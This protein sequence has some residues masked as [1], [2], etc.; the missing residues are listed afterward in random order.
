[1]AS[2]FGVNAFHVKKQWVCLCSWVCV[3]NQCAIKN[4][5]INIC[6]TAFPGKVVKTAH[7]AHILH[8]TLFQWIYLF[9]T[10]L[11]IPI[12]CSY[13]WCADVSWDPFFFFEWFIYFFTVNTTRPKLR[14]HWAQE[15]F[16]FQRIMKYL[17][18]FYSISVVSLCLF[19]TSVSSVDQRVNSHQ[20]RKSRSFCPSIASFIVGVNSHQEILLIVLIAHC[21]P[22]SVLLIPPGNFSF[23]LLHCQLCC[24]RR[25]LSLAQQISLLVLLNSN[26]RPS[27]LGPGLH[28]Y[29]PRLFLDRAPPPPFCYSFC[30]L[31]HIRLEPEV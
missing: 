14:F 15:N 19:C 4:R 27:I 6:S 25:K 18:L 11:F 31:V 20:W 29:P 22:L 2:K 10:F 7:R 17:L 13:W 1:M 12:S 30:M 26:C 28:F 21:S 5:L 24:S 23:I 3:Q 8:R 16:F 9:F